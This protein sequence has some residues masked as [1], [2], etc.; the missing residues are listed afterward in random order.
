MAQQG[1]SI[2]ILLIITLP[3]IPTIAFWLWMFRE[4]MNNDSLPPGSKENWT[5]LFLLLNVFAAM[6]YYV[7]EY[8]KR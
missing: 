1:P 2:L 8:Q 5:W 6:L 4:M 7:N 3:L